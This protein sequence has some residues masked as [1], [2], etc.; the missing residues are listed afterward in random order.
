MVLGFREWQRAKGFQAH[1]AAAFEAA[2]ANVERNWPDR[3]LRRVGRVSVNKDLVRTEAPAVGQGP[4]GPPGWGVGEER[5]P[6]SHN[7]KLRLWFR[8]G[9]PIA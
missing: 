2:K 7:N 1:G 6:P 3:R 8:S 5:L 4:T 9:W